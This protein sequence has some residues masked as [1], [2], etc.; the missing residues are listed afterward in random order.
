MKKK[1]L[2]TSLL[3]FAIIINLAAQIWNGSQDSI[4]REPTTFVEESG[5]DNIKF[6][7]KF[8][9]F[10]YDEI[11]ENGVVYQR[12]SIPGCGV[13]GNSGE[14][15]LPVL[16]KL[17][18]VPEFSEANVSI[19][20]KD[21]EILYNYNIYPNPTYVMEGLTNGIS[22]P[23][24]TF[25]IN[26]NYYNNNLINPPTHYL[27]SQNGYLRSQKFIEI[28]LYPFRY[29]P[30][31]K[32]IE[33]AKEI[34]VTI[35]FT[36]PQSPLPKNTGIF[37]K[38][39]SSA[40]INYNADGKSAIENDMVLN[41]GTT[42][43]ING[44]IINNLPQYT[45]YLVIY[46]DMFHINGEP[47]EEIKR[48][49]NHR[50]FYNGFD[51][52]ALSVKDILT[53]QDMATNAT[54]YIHETKLKNYIKYVYEN[55]NAK[56]T[57]DGKLGYVLLI[58]KPLSK[59]LAD[60]D[61]T[62]VPTSFIH[63]KGSI[64]LPYSIIPADYFLTCI[65][66]NDTIGDM[67]I[68]RFS[69]TNAEELY[70]IVE[71][72]TNKEISY[73]PIFQKNILYAEGRGCNSPNFR[74]FFKKIT[75][76]YNLQNVNNE[77]HSSIDTKRDSILLLLNAGTHHFYFNTHGVPQSWDLNLNIDTLR[78]HLNNT[79]MQGLCTSLSCGS[80]NVDSTF[81]TLGEMLTTY[82]PNKGFSAFLGASRETSF[83]TT[84]VDPIP[85]KFH[86]YLPFS[87]YNNLSTI[88][89]EILLS[90]IIN[91]NSVDSYSKFNFNLLGDPALNIMSHGMEV[92]NCITLPDS[93]VISS[94]IT[95][96]RSGCII[97][98]DNSYLSLTNNGSL[99]IEPG[100]RL[101]IG[102]NS[103]IE[104][105][106]NNSNNTIT[107]A[108]NGVFIEN[109]VEFKNLKYFSFISSN[110][111]APEISIDSAF[112]NNAPLHSNNCKI[113][114]SN[115]RFINRSDIVSNHCDID[116]RNNDFNQSGIVCFAPSI[117]SNT[118]GLS[119]KTNIADNKF[120]ATGSFSYP[121][122]AALGVTSSSNAAVK[123]D[124]IIDYSVTN[125]M[126][127]RCNEAIFVNNSGSVMSKMHNISN[128]NITKCSIGATLYNSY[129]IFNKNKI[130]NNN[131]GVLL[132]NNSCY[133]FNNYPVNNEENK[134]L[135]VSNA[136]QQLYSSNG[137]FPLLFHYNNV[138]GNSSHKWI[139]NDTYSEDSR[140]IDVSNNHWGDNS[141]FNPQLVFN[142]PDMFNWTPFWD[143]QPNGKSA[144]W[145]TDESDFYDALNYVSV[146]DYCNAK[147]ALKMVIDN[148]P[149]SYYSVAALK[150]LFRIEKMCDND[151][152]G[153]KDYFR[154]NQTI[155]STSN[156]FTISDF[157]GA[158]CDVVLEN[159]QSAINWYE[160]RLNNTTSYQDSVF[161]LIDLGD[162]YWM[163]QQDSIA[164]N[165]MEFTSLSFEQ[166][167][168]LANFQKFKNRLLSTLPK[169]LSVSTNILV[170]K[171]PKIIE[172][173][174]N[175]A[176]NDVT[177]SYYTNSSAIYQIKVY[178]IHGNLMDLAILSENKNDDYSQIRLNTSSLRNGI[179]F[180]TLYM[181]GQIIGTT[182]LLIN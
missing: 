25:V 127:S 85:S 136:T 142:V 58:G 128:N 64:D 41:R 20:I 32:K 53:S 107:V 27:Y 39:A 101:E 156:L 106:I 77:G 176:K 40:F 167:K 93:T 126:F 62:K 159:Y 140:Y 137:T 130:L 67:F 100:G 175:P 166:T 15:E 44:D 158:R 57:L 65:S 91:T 79:N 29:N 6:N 125:N 45:D 108:N 26:N 150:E 69:V 19:N 141:Q 138:Q 152:S 92:G 55:T 4:M 96:K 161:A 122:V 76:N 112:F 66:G 97:L 99:L 181:N 154:N 47:H 177:I 134:Q 120:A 51:V 11:E 94:P 119:A 21:S 170:N 131:T 163:A 168:S 173:S 90:S 171:N 9:G 145:P 88:T 22:Q 81:Q 116:I 14:P 102:N 5:S 135:L 24:E 144:N 17:V 80:T 18:A 86:E 182:K 28:V 60:T 52:T 151:Y 59:S 56:R 117:A 23:V 155:T 84:L 110:S 148:H 114:I 103:K 34:D 153:L 143:G 43:Y 8:H 164:K 71:K 157:L 35:S 2:I 1:L 146:N 179:Y 83:Y 16:K 115:S 98:P 50:A 30:A 174:P 3:S 124:N 105:E 180:V 75:T 36:N 118:P 162:I 38:I 149:E 95:V 160:N 12:I 104:G 87:L 37:N 133:Y 63:G 7:I 78:K 72:T 172:A 46:D 13:F 70:N 31:E 61:N 49:C 147:T 74:N 89:G 123:L 73:N 10:Y 178:S 82:A 42:T 132:F 48:I 33:F 121:V 129:G 165:N 68:G 169:K 54:S 111:N 109:G 113:T 139:Y